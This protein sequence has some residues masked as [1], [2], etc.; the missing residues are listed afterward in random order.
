MATYITF[1]RSIDDAPA[2]LSD[3]TL[4]GRRLPS[5][6]DLPEDERDAWNREFTR[7]SQDCGCNTGAL[8][9]GAALGVYIA[10]GMIGL[11]PLRFS[12][13]VLVFILAAGIGKL[14]GMNTVARRLDQA[15]SVA[16]SEVLRRR[17]PPDRPSNRE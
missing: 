16:S 7:L 5:L 14:V 6:E 4:L 1:A 2:P 13:G 12:F 11:M 15:I 8:V 9:A 17:N 3:R 10:A